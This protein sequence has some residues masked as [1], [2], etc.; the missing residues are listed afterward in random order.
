M[1]LRLIDNASASLRPVSHSVSLPAT[2]SATS[3]EI[4]FSV[5]DIG[6]YGAILGLTWL[7]HYNPDIDWAAETM[8]ARHLHAG[9]VSAAPGASA[10]AGLPLYAVQA[11]T[12]I[13]V[14]QD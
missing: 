13:R 8:T 1:P 14:L 9:E 4:R 11:D 3:G 7:K 12:V 5:A 2:T 6:D 10:Q